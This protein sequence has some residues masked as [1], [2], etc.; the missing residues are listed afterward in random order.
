[1]ARGQ[2]FTEQVQV[3]AQNTDTG[4]SR[5]AASVLQKLQQFKG[6]TENLINVTQTIAGQEE[7]QGETDIGKK[8]EAGLAEKILTGGVKTAAYNKALETSYLA[9]L[10]NDTR[11]AIA[12]IEAENTSDINA[13]NE[14][15]NGYING[16]LK[17]VDPSV[18]DRFAQFADSQITNARIRVHSNTI[19]KNKQQA[20]AESSL[21]I[22]DFGREAATLARE[23]NQIGS[24]EAI[25]NSFS[26]IDGLVASED[27][28][29]DKAASLK[30]GIEREAS[31]QTLR[32]QIDGLV[33]SEGVEA[34]FAK[35]EEIENKPAKGWTPDEWDTFTRSA[36][37]DIN[38]EAVRQQKLKAEVKLNSAKEVSDLKIKA[39]T[40]FGMDGKPVAPS[41]IIQETDKF[42]N[43]GKISGN[44]R[45]SII[46]GVINAQKQSVESSLSKQLVADRLGGDS[47]IALTQ[48]DIDVAWEEELQTQ[49]EAL[50]AEYKSASIAEFVNSTKMIPT[51]VNR[52]IKNNLR[53]DDP[54]VVADSANLID[55]LDSIRGLNDMK[56]TPTERAFANSVTGLMQNMEPNEA[57]KLAR[58]NTDPNDEGRVQARVKIIKDEKFR[59]NYGDVVE[60]EFGGFFG[61]V[62][63]VA[64]GQLEKEYS[65]LFEEHFKAG[66]DVDAAKEKA[67]QLMGRNWGET[68]ATKKSR[69]MKY[70]PED[71]YAVNG[72]VEYIQKDLW[73]S[74]RSSSIGLPE[75]NAEDITLISDQTTAR[76]ATNGKPSY[77]VMIDN[78]ENGLFPLVGFRYIP[79]YEAQIE[80]TKTENEKRLA[81][82]RGTSVTAAEQR[83]AIN[84]LFEKR[85]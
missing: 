31:E 22:E 41:Q 37:A 20:V 50:P 12:G 59:E 40:G 60:S 85:F 77:M 6:S 72:S 84:R 32:L 28:T 58:Q 81:E 70:P 39:S 67:F 64:L 34:A 62:D 45:S 13:F 9:G 51:Q 48:K 8:R 43:E 57:I 10:S 4:F 42:F 21:A 38:N 29:V 19:R 33:E 3:Q 27:I 36:R 76:E 55:R 80:A 75:F 68:N 18:R 23:G 49:I 69:T 47:T 5:G 71:Y 25:Q 54:E 11:E 52:Q 44:E 7:A 79:D 1:M 46:S 83:E 53:S 14:K 35:I 15:V 24:A 63:P 17:E 66:M 74:I 56:L 78:G 30:R 2:R 26:I 82:E 61:S 73:K 16:A 65:V